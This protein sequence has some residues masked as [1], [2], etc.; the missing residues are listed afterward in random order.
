MHRITTPYPPVTVE[1]AVSGVSTPSSIGQVLAPPAVEETPAINGDQPGRF[2]VEWVN[3]SGHE[4]FCGKAS[5]GIS[6]EQ[7]G[8]LIGALVRGGRATVFNV[9]RIG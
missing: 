7:V 5:G 6:P 1:T 8:R 3:P 9:T 4:R 2:L